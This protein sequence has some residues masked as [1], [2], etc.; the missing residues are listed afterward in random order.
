MLAMLPV[1][2]TSGVEPIEFYRNLQRG[3]STFQIGLGSAAIW[4]LAISFEIGGLLRLPNLAGADDVVSL[5]IA[6]LVYATGYMALRQPEIFDLRRSESEPPNIQFKA[7]QLC[8]TSNAVFRQHTGAYS[9]F[10][11]EVG[12]AEFFLTSSAAVRWDFHRPN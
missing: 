8:S 1:L 10:L 9:F 3:G 6:I 4:A 7:R 2:L 5:A 11:S 12:C